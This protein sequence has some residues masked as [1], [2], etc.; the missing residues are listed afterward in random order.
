V[1]FGSAFPLATNGIISDAD[2]NSTLAKGVTVVSRNGNSF[3]ALKPVLTQTV[4]TI[5]AGSDPL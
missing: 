4:G 2:R 5:A 1:N 3:G